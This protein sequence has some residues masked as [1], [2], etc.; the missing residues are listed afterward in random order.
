MIVDR[1]IF[2]ALD[3]KIKK[4]KENDSKSYERRKLINLRKLK[5]QHNSVSR[6]I[7]K[8]DERIVKNILIGLEREICEEEAKK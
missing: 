5:K 1:K 4:I 3:E 7:Y 8:I 6:F 2:Q